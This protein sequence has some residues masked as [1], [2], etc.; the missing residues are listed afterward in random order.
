MTTTPK[1][2]ED[3]MEG[4]GFE[5]KQTSFKPA[6]VYGY[7]ERANGLTVTPYQAK[8]M[9]KQSILSRIDALNH[10]QSVSSGGGSWRRNIISMV[11]ELQALLDKEG[12]QDE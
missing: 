1:T 12:S 9:F 6:S 11:A 5:F 4:L 8:F 2:V 7:W 10:L 3:Y